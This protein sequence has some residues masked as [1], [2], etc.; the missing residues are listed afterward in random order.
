MLL[1]DVYLENLIEP[2]YF[3]DANLQA[4]IKVKGCTVT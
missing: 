3:S 1:V 4:I 2:I